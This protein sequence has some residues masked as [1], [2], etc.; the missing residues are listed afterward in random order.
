LHGLFSKPPGASRRAERNE[1][2]ITVSGVSRDPARNVVCQHISPPACLPV[3]LHTWLL[4][5]RL[6]KHQRLGARA[7]FTF[8]ALMQKR[9][10]E[11]EEKS[12]AKKAKAPSAKEKSTNSRFPQFEAPNGN[13]CFKEAKAARQLVNQGP[14]VRCML[15][16]NTTSH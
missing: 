1:N 4:Q 13:P 3:C 11:H 15:N 6:S 16:I 12:S 8:F 9:A 2:S 14:C 5:L 10:R 7:F